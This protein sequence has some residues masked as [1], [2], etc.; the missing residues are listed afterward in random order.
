[1]VGPVQ[2]TARLTVFMH[3]PTRSRAAQAGAARALAC[4]SNNGHVTPSMRWGRGIQCFHWRAACRHDAA[5]RGIT[6]RG[7]RAAMRLSRD[8]QPTDFC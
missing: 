1:M 5:V 3:A 8:S 7:S 2:R 6:R 4:P